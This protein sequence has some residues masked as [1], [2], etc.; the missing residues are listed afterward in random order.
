[1]MLIQI[2]ISVF[3]IGLHVLYTDMF[4]NNVCDITIAT[5]STKVNQRKHVFA[6]NWVVRGRHS[7]E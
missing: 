7:T 1:M 6:F 2:T 5:S 4:D 3:V